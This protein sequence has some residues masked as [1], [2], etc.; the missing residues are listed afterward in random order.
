MLCLPQ[1]SS[2]AVCGQIGIIS[3]LCKVL[4]AK[5]DCE[6]CVLPT[7]R[8]YLHSAECCTCVCRIVVPA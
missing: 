6:I 4:V 7:R 2:E 5:W 3:T 1:S 8:G